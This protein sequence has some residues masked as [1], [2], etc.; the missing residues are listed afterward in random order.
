MDEPK[1]PTVT[2]VHL[3]RSKC[4]QLGKGVDIFIGRTNNRLCPV[5]AILA[6]M[7]NRGSMPGPFFRLEDGSPLVKSYFITQ[8]REALKTAGLP[9]DHFAGHSFRIGA[10]T[11]A[12]SVDIEDSAIRTLGRWNSSAFRCS[13]RTSRQ[14]LTRVSAMLAKN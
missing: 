9:Y 14:Q 13:V 8:I 4:N 11:T 5:A 12:A 2:K 3:K 10:A 1:N 6:Y 7:V